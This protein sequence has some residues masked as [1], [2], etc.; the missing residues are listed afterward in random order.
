MPKSHPTYLTR[1]RFLTA[2]AAS[3]AGF[4]SLNLLKAQT[5]SG[6]G[7]QQ[8]VKIGYLAI[9]DSTPLVI[10][11]ANKLYEAEGLNT[12]QPVH[13]RASKCCPSTEP[14]RDLVAVQQKISC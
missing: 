12:E 14:D 13:C 4:A 8:P 2:A 3:A 1:R 11:H 5:S 9:T 6:K 10:A 7:T